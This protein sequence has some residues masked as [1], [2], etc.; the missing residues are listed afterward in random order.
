MSFSATLN[1]HSDTMQLRAALRLGLKTLNEN[2][3]PSSQLA[4]ELLLK[5]GVDAAGL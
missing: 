5:F 2:Q 1:S 3:V 4:A